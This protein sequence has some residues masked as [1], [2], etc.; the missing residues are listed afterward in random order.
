MGLPCSFV[1]HVFS[2]LLIVKFHR[3]AYSKWTY[4]TCVLIRSGVSDSFVTPWAVA[5]QIPLSVG[6][7]R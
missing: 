5:L 7:P 1:K 3:L 4:F 6:F 2:K